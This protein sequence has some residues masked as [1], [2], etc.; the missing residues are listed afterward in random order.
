MKITEL[1]T[2]DTVLLDLQST[3]K[4]GV[5]EELIEKLYQAGKITDKEAFK[6]DILAREAQG[7]TGIGEGIAI[8]HA[9]SSAVKVPAL[10]FGR[11]TNGVEYE[12]L[13][14]QP[15]HLFFMI[16]A[17]EGANQQHLDTLARL[18]SMLMDTSFREQLLAANTEEELLHIINQKD[19]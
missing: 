18:A 17:S 6:K 12:S 4:P 9:K 10:V 14:G 15:V 19:T 11:S 13:D 8:P 2:K 16:A 1:L 5:I 7:S 3:E